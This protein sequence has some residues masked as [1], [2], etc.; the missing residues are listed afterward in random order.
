MA[1]LPTTGNW[2]TDAEADRARAMRFTKRRSEWMLA[3]YVGKC[4]VVGRLGLPS[5]ADSLRRVEIRAIAEGEARGAPEIFVDGRPSTLGLSLTDRAGW[6]ACV[7]G[8]A[9]DLG[10]D[11]RVGCDLELV[12]PRTAGF[13][14]DFFTDAERAAVANPPGGASSALV[15]NLVWSAKESALKVLRTG[16]RGDTRSVEVRLV[17]PVV[18]GWE[19]LRARTAEGDDLPGWWHSY[20]EFLFT[21]V[22]QREQPPPR[23]LVDPPPLAAARPTHEWLSTPLAGEP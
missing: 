5:D 15:A 11:R 7:L 16:L 21:V 10:E 19:S 14:G 18:E 12:E 20:G 4:A 1:S 13:V 17:G 23:P 8:D 2:L 9:G 6:A 3:R 22:T